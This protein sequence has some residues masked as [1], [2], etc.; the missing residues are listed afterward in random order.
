MKTLIRLYR[1]AILSFSV[2]LSVVGV[3]D[4]RAAGIAGPFHNP[5]N[6][7]D[8]YLLPPST[9]SQ[10]AF[11]ARDMGNGTHLV[12]IGCYAENQWVLN[13]FRGLIPSLSTIWIGLN[14]AA[15][16]GAWVWESG[17]PV[18]F[19]N[20][21]PGQPDNAQNAGDGTD[22][23]FAHMWMFD[24][25]GQKAGEWDDYNN[26]AF[27]NTAYGVA[28]TAGPDAADCLGNPCN[29]DLEAGDCASCIEYS[30]SSEDYYCCMNPSDLRCS[31]ECRA[32]TP[33]SEDYY[34]CVHPGDLPRCSAECRALPE[35]SDERY[36]CLN[37]TDAPRCT[38]CKGIP[39]GTE[40]YYC[41]SNTD[42]N[43]VYCKLPP[44]AGGSLRVL[45][46]ESVYEPG[47]HRV[48]FI[49]NLSKLP[50]RDRVLK[51]LKSPTLISADQNGLRTVVATFSDDGI[52][53]AGEVGDYIFAVWV[54]V[55]VPGRGGLA[56]C[57]R[58]FFAS[59]A[60]RGR[61]ARRFSNS[62][63]I[64]SSDGCCGTLDPCC[65]HSGE[66]GCGDGDGDGGF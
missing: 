40:D 12:S 22:Q 17:Q 28:E 48:L 24:Y 56:S 38:T 19:V 53:E 21:G 55:E 23:D 3:Q 43:D 59:T 45:P 14:D 63:S 50:D 62:V 46:A 11:M 2:L 66:P 4:L 13:T 57:S 49:L 58:T 61:A 47:W 20:W 8:Y 16:E 15:K 42:S 54:E 65:G 1:I 35:G 39:Q 9:Y 37:P 52:P 60:F 26:S 30:P 36:C 7:H 25:L 6:G 33:G 32:L 5:S 18:T 27:S 10:A 31:A 29:G 41:C 34:C 51:N 64:T 44:P